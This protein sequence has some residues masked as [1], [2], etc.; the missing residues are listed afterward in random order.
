[1]SLILNISMEDSSLSCP[2][3]RYRQGGGDHHHVSNTSTTTATST[4]T[5]VKMNHEKKNPNANT[6]FCKKCTHA[7]LY[8]AIEKHK[9]ALALR[10]QKRQECDE[11]L[12]HLRSTASSVA[13]ATSSLSRDRGGGGH[14]TDGHYGVIQGP[15]SAHQIILKYQHR[16][17]ELTRDIEVKRQACARKSVALASCAMMQSN[18]SKAI[19][20]HRQL[21]CDLRSQLDALHHIVMIGQDSHGHENKEEEEEEEGKMTNGVKRA[22]KKVMSLG[23]CGEGGGM[24]IG[25]VGLEGTME[26]YISLVQKR[27]FQLALEAFEMHRMDVGSEYNQLSFDDLL[28]QE[29]HPESGEGD[30]DGNDDD[31]SSLGGIKKNQNE[32]QTQTHTTATTMESKRFQR[33]VQQRVPSGIGKIGGLLMPHR[34]PLHFDGVLPHNILVSSLRMIASLTCLLARCLSIELPHPI[35]L[36]PIA[37]RGGGRGEDWR[38]IRDQTA[39]IMDSSCG[40]TS[41]NEKNDKDHPCSHLDS[42]ITL[43]KHVDDLVVM[44]NPTSELTP[45]DKSVTHDKERNRAPVVSS[46]SHASNMMMRQ[47]PP[48]TSVKQSTSASSLMS[49][50]GSSSKLISHSARKAFDK[51]TGHHHQQQRNHN[52]KSNVNIATVAMDGDAVALRVKFASCAIIYESIPGVNVSN[53]RYEL[54]PPSTTADRKTREKAEEQFSIALQLLQNDIIALSIKAGVPIS[55]LW[56]AEAMCL[57]LHSL[58]LFLSQALEA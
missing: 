49:L 50:V 42:G 12:R 10:Q 39:D 7:L 52:A 28:Q 40:L 11:T 46:S 47:Y 51:M 34:G 24:N 4:S 37:Q 14:T 31:G 13:A 44:N 30:R 9:S 57:N 16:I 26:Y 48:G 2:C 56:P 3:Q 22:A 55:M 15:K 54:R 27:R 35:V 53:T 32:T 45:H 43:M 20:E 19:E 1:M 41:C 29:R 38:W 25:P 23:G 36:C 33:L 18:R 58:K 8:N 21:V 6:T 5:K 17:E